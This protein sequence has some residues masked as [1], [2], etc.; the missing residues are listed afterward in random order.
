MELTLVLLCMFAVGMLSH[1]ITRDVVNRRNSPMD[2][3]LIVNELQMLESQLRWAQ[4]P[5]IGQ[6]AFREAILRAAIS[7][8]YVEKMVTLGLS[9]SVSE[10]EYFAAGEM[11][12]AYL[13]SYDRTDTDDFHEFRMLMS[14]AR[15]YDRGWHWTAPMA[16]IDWLEKAEHITH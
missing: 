8:L 16:Y 7:H 9:A 11:V 5:W 14:T 4:S 12:K 15:L 3:R 1:V 6:E 13:V 2:R 10:D